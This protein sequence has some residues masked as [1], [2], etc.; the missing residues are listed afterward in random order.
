MIERQIIIALITSTEFHQRLQGKWSPVLIES[1]TAKRIASWCLEY[2]NQYSKAPGKDIGTIFYAKA[3][4]GLPKDIAEEIEQ[5]ILPDLSDDFVNQ[6]INV[7]YVVTEALN[8]FE[9]RHL[10][11]YNEEGLQLIQSGQL[12]EARKHALNYKPIANDNSTWVDFSD[13][14]V[15]NRIEQAFNVSG[16]C[17]IRYHGALGRFFNE[18]LCR[19]KFVGFQ[20]SS[21]R[22]KTFELIELANRACRQKRNVA[23]F[24]A[25][26]MT[27]GEMFIRESIYLTKKSNKEK[28]CAEHFEPVADC[29]LN[30]LNKCN[31]E[32]RNCDFGVFEGK[33]EKYLRNEITLEELKESYEENYDY[34][35]CTFCDD[36]KT[37]KLGTPWV[38]KIK[39]V[40]PLTVQEAKL[41]FDK[42]F[43]RYKRSFKLSSHTAG[44]LSVKQMKSIL[45]IW[46]KQ[47]GFIPDVIIVD[48]ADIMIDEVVKD[49]KER[50]N[51]IWRDL[52]GLSQSE[53]A[54][55]ISPT[56]ADS[57][58]FDKDTMS[59]K[60][61][62][63]D[64]RKYDHVT[65]MWG[66][67]Q[68]KNGREKEIGIMRFNELAIREGEGNEKNQVYVLQN[69]RKGKS[70]LSSYF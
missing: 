30:Q 14:T 43:I 12:I 53:K 32:E 36:Y 49:P 21:K 51:V 13:P 6:T 8:Y 4:A 70:Y 48:Y 52:R 9:E 66:M 31:K 41:A 45:A 3:K 67:N 58:S 69:L 64:R 29:V 33:N 5:D 20:A 34:K 18:H 47:D 1:Q 19:G 50:E 11:K 63:Q 23:F 61:F 17:L 59:K 57:D 16:E 27:E 10:L 7:D 46:R 38:K 37:N 54:L 39:K 24:S 65:A 44:T 26:D 2:F 42:F 56:Q 22:G 28:Y 68:D 25:G 15:L 55:V 62:S 60:N 40:E 35:P